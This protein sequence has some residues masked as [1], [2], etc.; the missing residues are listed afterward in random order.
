M[1]IKN[2]DNDIFSFISENIEMAR[3]FCFL[4]YTEDIWIWDQN[5]EFPEIIPDVLKDYEHITF[6]FEPTIF[7][8]LLAR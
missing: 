1:Y 6:L 2:Y 4:L 8:F 5:T 3:P 7:S